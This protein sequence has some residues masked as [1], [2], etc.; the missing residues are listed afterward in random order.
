MGIAEKL[1]KA[2]GPNSWA[3]VGPQDF[4]PEHDYELEDHGEFWVFQPVSE[5]ALQWGYAKF[6]ADVPRWG[7]KGIKIETEHLELILYRA[8]QDG[9][10]SLQDFTTA[11]H[12]NDALQH[13]A[14]GQDNERH[15]T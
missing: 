10:L 7:A 15:D 5:A 1:P 14:E 2:P 4:G 13:Q 6:P 8:R 12:E 9:L 11:M 3:E